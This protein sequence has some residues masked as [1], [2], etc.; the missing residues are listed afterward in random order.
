M[1]ER[2]KDP[3][4]A[5]VQLNVPITWE[6]REHLTKVAFDRHTS[7]AALVRDTLEERYP[8]LAERARE[9]TRAAGATR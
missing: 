2:I 8:M 5:K 7:L 6:H 1:P 3:R 4:Q 9:E